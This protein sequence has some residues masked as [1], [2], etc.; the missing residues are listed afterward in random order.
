MNPNYAWV[1]LNWSDLLLVLERDEEAFAEA[2]RLIELDPLWAGAYMKMGQL[3]CYRRYYDRALEQI[4]RSLELDPNFVWAYAFLAQVYAWKGRYDEG[5]AACEKVASL[6]E[7][8]PYGTA[9]RGLILAMAGRSD[10]AKAIL[11]E[12]KKRPKLDSV[13]LMGIA[14]TYS[15]LG[16]KDE[17][18]EFLEAAYKDRAGWLIFL[19]IRPTFDNIPQRFSLR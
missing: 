11:T 1:Y 15:V 9:L 16:E 13:A 14:D 10:E 3:F 19:G 8:K 2:R 18:F 7:D 5:L 4:E 6:L 17:A 12:L